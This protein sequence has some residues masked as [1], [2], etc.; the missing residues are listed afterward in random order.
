MLLLTLA[1]LAQAAATPAPR[2]VGTYAVE[3]A[4]IAA[5]KVMIRVTFDRAMRPDS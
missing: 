3:G 2:V 4:V 5:G 1:L